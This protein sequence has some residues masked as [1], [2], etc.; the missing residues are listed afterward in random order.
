MSIQHPGG[1]VLST[2]RQGD[3]GVDEFPQCQSHCE[4]IGGRHTQLDVR[5]D[6]LEGEDDPK[7]IVAIHIRQDLSKRPTVY[8]VDREGN[9]VLQAYFE[10]WSKGNCRWLERPS[11]VGC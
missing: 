6:I 9:F 1:I 5:P 7:P 4:G 2:Y 8:A 3:V 11:P 10:S